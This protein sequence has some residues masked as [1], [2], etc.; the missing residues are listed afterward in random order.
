MRLTWKQAEE[1]LSMSRRAIQAC[2][3]EALG[4][5][6]LKPGSR[7]AILEAEG[8]QFSLAGRLVWIGR[9]GRIYVVRI[10]A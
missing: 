4:R 7:K 8:F 6:V 5:N 2:A 10:R 3:F 9:R 1:V